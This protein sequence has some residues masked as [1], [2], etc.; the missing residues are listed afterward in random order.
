MSDSQSN[1]FILNESE[2]FRAFE[3]GIKSFYNFIEVV[4]SF[5]EVM[6]GREMEDVADMSDFQMIS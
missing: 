5:D 2:L 4:A 3:I 6:I 1:M